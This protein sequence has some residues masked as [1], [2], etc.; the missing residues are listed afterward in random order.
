MPVYNA[1]NY[2]LQSM[3]S[4]AESTHKNLEVIIVD[5]CSTDKTEEIIHNFIKNDDRFFYFHNTSNR[6]VSISRNNAL[7]KITGEYIT[8]VDSDD[9][10]SKD[11]IENLVDSAI[12]KD[13]HIVIGKTKQVTNGVETD[14]KIKELDDEP[15]ELHFSSITLHKNAVVW[16]KL[17]RSDL[18]IN[19]HIYFAPDIYIGEDLLFNYKAIYYALKVFYNN[20]GYYYYRKDNETSIMN[21]SQAENY[22]RNIQKVLNSI[23][24]FNNL[25]GDKN[26]HVMKKQ[27]KDILR[28]YYLAD[29]N[30]KINMSELRS[31]DFIAPE[32]VKLNL[33]RKHLFR[34]KQKNKSTGNKS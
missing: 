19:N 2:V 28:K 10:I 29:K 7:R 9:Y 1:E 20:K 14:Y 3:K 32:K 4:I 33:L 31:V 6:N 16:N 12:A 5:D 30:C 23:I 25:V 22:C 24:N 17:Y 13:A 21:K 15:K 18:I 26:I 8:F 34:K 27:V 11:W